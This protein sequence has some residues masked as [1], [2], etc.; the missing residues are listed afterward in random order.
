MLKS[1]IPKWIH[2]LIQVVRD[3]QKNVE[4]KS[5]VI[6]WFIVLI[7]IIEQIILLNPKLC[8]FY[9]K[10]RHHLGIPRGVSAAKF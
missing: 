9:V 10:T 6:G 2:K 4:R 8:A 3:S 7:S 1:P 5:I